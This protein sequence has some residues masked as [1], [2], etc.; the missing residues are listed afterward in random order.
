MVI[1][2]GIGTRQDR[3]GNLVDILLKV[4]DEDVKAIV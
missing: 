4:G 1:T 2:I 3:S